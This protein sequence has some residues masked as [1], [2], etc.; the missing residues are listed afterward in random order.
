MAIS[1]LF[2][3]SCTFKVFSCDELALQMI[4]WTHGKNEMQLG[5]LSQKILGF[6]KLKH[7]CFDK[8]SLNTPPKL[9]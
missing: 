4:N 9:S 5:E 3:Y 2:L 6:F 1:I 7:I 8:L